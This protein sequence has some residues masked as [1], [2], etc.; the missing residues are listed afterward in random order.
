MSRT[1]RWRH[2]RRAPAARDGLPDQGQAVHAEQA[3][4][5]RQADLR[6]RGLHNVDA[7]RR[8][9]GLPA[10][11]RHHAREWPTPEFTLEFVYDLLMHYGTDPD[12][13]NL[14]EK[15]KLI[16]V[17]VVNPDGYDLSRSL[18]NEQKRKNCRITSGVIPTLA[19]CMRR[20]TSTAAS[21]STATTS[22]SGA[23]R[24]RARA[25]RRPTRAARPRVPSPRSRA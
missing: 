25:R 10:H 8:Q 23:A 17:P 5:A 21:T 2:Q 16:A 22:R 14:L 15:G 3:V 9:A 24:A 20:R 6:R 11:R 4:A 18:Q 12:A 1:A 19:E 13:K 7:E